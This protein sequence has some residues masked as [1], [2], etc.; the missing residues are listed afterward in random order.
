MDK[1]EDLRLGHSIS[2]NSERLLRR[3]KGEPGYIGVF[4]TKTKYRN[5]KGL[6]LIKENQ[7]SQVKEFSAFLCMGRCK[8]WAHWNHSFDMYLSY[9]G[10]SLLCFLILSLLRVHR[11]RAHHWGGYNVMAWWRQHPL[12]TDMAGNIFHLQLGCFILPFLLPPSPC[13]EHRQMW[14]L[15]V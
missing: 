7:T 4:A 5:I 2:D 6:L 10:A 15:K 14:C 1:T 8:I 11:C 12:F 3:D 9:L 13:L